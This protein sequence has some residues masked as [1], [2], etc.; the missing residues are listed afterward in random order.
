MIL[1]AG[2]STCFFLENSMFIISLC[3]KYFSIV[4]LR[5]SISTNHRNACKSLVAKAIAEQQTH[6]KD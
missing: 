2:N 6:F 5:N 1:N 3:P 4:Y